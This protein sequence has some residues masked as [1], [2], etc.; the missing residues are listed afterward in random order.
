MP[1]DF[2]GGEHQ[3]TN[4]TRR[5]PLRETTFIAPRQAR[6]VVQ[7]VEPFA[8]D[9]Q[10]SRADFAVVALKLRHRKELVHARLQVLEDVFE[11]LRNQLLTSSG[12]TLVAGR[13]RRNLVGT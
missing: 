5:G 13:P 1:R 11:R 4:L 8:D 3:P 6:S 10:V 9:E 2:L 7:G 12:W